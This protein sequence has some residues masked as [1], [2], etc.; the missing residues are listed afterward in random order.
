MLCASAEYTELSLFVK[1]VQPSLCT[2]LVKKIASTD[3]S[4]RVDMEIVEKVH[5]K[6]EAPSVQAQ[7]H[8][9]PSPIVEGGQQGKDTF[10]SYQEQLDELRPLVNARLQEGTLW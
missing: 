1:Y 3:V 8:D 9:T 6:V 7:L 4:R 10:P 2:R 5:Q